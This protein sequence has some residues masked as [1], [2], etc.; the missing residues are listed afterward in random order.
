MRYTVV[1]LLMFILVLTPSCKR[2]ERGFRVQPPSAGT[3]NAKALSELQPGQPS[4]VAGVKNQY[5]ENAYALSEGKRLFS[6]YNCN[7]CHAMGGGG[8]GPPLMDEK[9]I[10]GGQPDQVFS[11]IIEGRP[12]GMPSFRGR[13]PDFQAWQLSAY[14]RSMS[15]H[16]PK[17]AAP[18]R[19]DH[20][21]GKPPENQTKE[22]PIKT[23]VVPQ[24][25]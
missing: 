18:S 3:I 19:D 11:T 15:G 1:S 16:A 21:Q 20:L 7:G 23:T 24:A 4:P 2:E 9:W 8:M 14:V 17:D 10:Y 25:Q 5:E 12:N 6:A 22:Q 13:V